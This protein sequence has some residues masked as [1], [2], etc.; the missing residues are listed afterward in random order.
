MQT[1]VRSVNLGE[2]IFV[3][4]GVHWALMSWR[5]HYTWFQAGPSFSCSEGLPGLIWV[6]ASWHLKTHPFRSV[7]LTLASQHWFCLF[8]LTATTVFCF[9]VTTT[10]AAFKLLIWSDTFPCKPHAYE[11]SYSYTAHVL[12]AGRVCIAVAL[13]KLWMSLPVLGESR[14]LTEYHF[15]KMVA[16]CHRRNKVYCQRTRDFPSRS[17]VLV[18]FAASEC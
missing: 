18:A 5:P 6:G 12:S 1:A 15:R 11:H 2:K 13:L 7:H 17:L 16:S 4:L 9:V 14:N 8:P 3:R 10:D